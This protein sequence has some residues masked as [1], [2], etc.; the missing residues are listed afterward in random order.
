MK[1]ADLLDEAVERARRIVEE[2]NPSL[3]EERKREVADMVG[4][5]AVKYADLLPNR[6]S[7]YAF[8]WDAMLSL[9]GNT[10]PYLQ[11]AYT[12]TRGVFRRFSGDL[13]GVL[14][15]ARLRLGAPEERDLA[16]HLADFPLALRAVAEECRPNYLCL[17]LYRLAG[18]L[19]RF[20]ESCPILKAPGEE[21][22]D[23][24]LLL[25]ERAGAVLGKGLELLGIRTGEAM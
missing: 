18:L 24:R 11:Y 3:D 23:S 16:R 13:A 14:G 8:D 17:Y 25:A 22:R 10:A 1:L 19:A 2:R 7:D 4:I 15:R 5:G 9:K 21:I 12:R 20:Y 6:Q